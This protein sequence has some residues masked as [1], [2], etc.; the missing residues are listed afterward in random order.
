MKIDAIF[1]FVSEDAA[2]QFT[3][4]CLVP[5]A[6]RPTILEWPTPPC[7]TPAHPRVCTVRPTGTNSALPNYWPTPPCQTP[8][9]PCACTV[10]PTQGPALPCPTIAQLLP[11]QLLRIHAPV[12]SVIQGP[13]PPCPTPAHPCACTVYHTVTNS[14]LAVF[15]Q[16]PQTHPC[17]RQLCP[18]LSVSL[19]LLRRQFALSLPC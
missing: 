9:H 7:P 12:P 1:D 13:I 6:P 5:H 18:C 17:M 14:S 4:S 8:A 16:S 11:A 10:R 15:M 19:L 3:H 2:Q